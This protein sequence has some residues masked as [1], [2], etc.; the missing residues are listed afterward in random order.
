MRWG[1]SARP[2][3]ALAAAGVVAMLLLVGCASS[4]RPAE[5]LNLQNL[6]APQQSAPVDPGAIVLLERAI[7]EDRLLDAR[8]LLDRL[9]LSEAAE[10]PRLRLAHA[11]LELASGIIKPA[12]DRFAFLVEEPSVGAR[13]LQGVGITR[14]LLGERALGKEALE[15]AVIVDPTL[16]RA[17]NALGY[18]LDSEQN[19]A[20][21]T[22]AYTK[23]IGLKPDYAGAHNNRG[24]SL[25][26]QRKIEDAIKDLNRALALDPKLAM[27][28]QNLRLAVAWRGD[29]QAA[30]VGVDPREMGRALNNVGYIA[31]MRGDTAA[32]EAYF[33]RAIEVDPAYNETAARNLAYLR[34]IKGLPSNP[35]RPG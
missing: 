28:R 4:Q 34:S 2:R 3:G 32:A 8:R 20:A 30:L 22:E 19:Y 17:W 1:D 5:P 35:A 29:Y 25:M 26:M 21:A 31:M 16:A 18:A 23:A 13:A 14:L 7:A 11:E 24:F 12:H 15:R 6:L 33:L 10:T 27:A 9:R